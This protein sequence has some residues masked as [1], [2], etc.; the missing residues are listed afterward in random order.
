M[1][2]VSYNFF[3]EGIMEYP[4]LL[5][6]PISSLFSVEKQPLSKMFRNEDRFR[7]SDCL[8][9]DDRLALP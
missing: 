5:G 8:F 1:A 4:C 2:D 7:H 6:S 9:C 3:L